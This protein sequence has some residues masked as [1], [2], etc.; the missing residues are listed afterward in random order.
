[1]HA[2]P[3]PGLSDRPSLA[4]GANEDFDGE[5]PVLAP[6]LSGVGGRHCRPWLLRC[7]GGQG[8]AVAWGAG[9]FPEDEGGTAPA[10][11]VGLVVDRCS[12]VPGGESQVCIGRLG[13]KAH[14]NGIA[15]NEAEQ[16]RQRLEAEC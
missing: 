3:L 6:F 9:G 10:G 14:L 7:N 16:G 4:L 2:L 11:G 8:L 5:V 15:R 12:D 1:M 13:D